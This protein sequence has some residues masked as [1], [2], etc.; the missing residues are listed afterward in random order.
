MKPLRR[1]WAIAQKEFR[2]L[3]RDRLT[4][5]MVVGIPLILITMFG[6]AINMD[7]RG[8]RAG[9]ADQAGTQTSRRLVADL[10]ATQVIAPVRRVGTAEELEEL[11]LRNE[12]VVGIF[13]PRDFERRLQDPNREAAQ[14]LVDATDPLI[15]RTVSAVVDMPFGLR[16][17]A[18]SPRLIP[19]PGRSQDSRL[20]SMRQYYNPERR[21]AVM[22]VPGTIGVILTFTMVLFTSIAI[23]RERERGNLELLITTPVSSIELMIGK[24]IPYIF[25]GM[26]QVSL[27][28][29]AAVFLFDVPLRGTLVDL[30]LASLA[31]VVAVLGLGLLIST[32]ARVQFQAFQLTFFILL[33]SILLSGF[34]FPFDGMPLPAQRFAQILPLTH[35]VVLVRG[36]LLKGASLVDLAPPLQKLG[37]LFLVSM[38]LAMLRFRK[39]L[40]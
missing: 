31:Y 36:I 7:V 13:I 16:E 1:T 25:I 19:R 22:I 32:I 30:Y 12:I 21:S 27:I 23:V 24:I 17:H 6:Y 10:A 35:F 18:A 15:P 11:L 14:L 9:V 37:I 33:P 5:A 20:F 4:F 3:A 26:L 39:R 29:A 40:D 8:L 2:Q 38:T 28:L 34:I